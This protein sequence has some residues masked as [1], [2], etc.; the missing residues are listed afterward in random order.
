MGAVTAAADTSAA[1]SM[2]MKTTT[3]EAE[4]QNTIARIQAEADRRGDLDMVII[5]DRALRGDRAS[6][7]HVSHPSVVARYA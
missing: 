2:T 7:L 6:R 3:T 5:C 4:F 1:Y